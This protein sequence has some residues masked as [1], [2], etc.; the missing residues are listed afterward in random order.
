MTGTYLDE[1]RVSL[2]L[3]LSSIN[4]PK[5]AGS[6]SDL[7]Y[8]VD[9]REPIRTGSIAT[10]PNFDVLSRGF[11]KVTDQLPHFNQD[12]YTRRHGQGNQPPNVLYFALRAFAPADD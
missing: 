3:T 11:K 5:R 12:E 10:F 6:V 1:W 9:S 8:I 2:K 7:T 4:A